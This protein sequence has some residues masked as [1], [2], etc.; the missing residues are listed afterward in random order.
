MALQGNL[1][2]DMDF[3]RDGLGK[4]MGSSRETHEKD[5]GNT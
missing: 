4:N 2:F 1:G 5:M 3:T